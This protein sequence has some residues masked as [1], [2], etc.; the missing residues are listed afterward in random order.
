MRAQQIQ[1]YG[2]LVLV[3][4]E[5]GYVTIYAHLDSIGVKRGDVVS[6]GQRIGTV[7][8]SGN[9]REP[10]LHFEIREKG[11]VAV[12]PTKFLD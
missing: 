6:A 5:N 4:H 12:D 8:K 7:G 9:V 10:Q 1:G 2:K 3:K 11:K